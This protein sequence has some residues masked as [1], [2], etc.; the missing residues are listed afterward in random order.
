MLFLTKQF[1]INIRRFWKSSDLNF[2]SNV[3]I[4][5]LLI[6]HYLFER[7]IV[8]IINVWKKNSRSLSQIYMNL[9]HGAF[10]IP[11]NHDD[12]QFFQANICCIMFV[13][14]NGN[15]VNSFFG[16]RLLVRRKAV[17]LTRRCSDLIINNIY[18][19]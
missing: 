16:E 7:Y 18:L 9:L 14:H 8:L 19:T 6:L 3:N 5:I 17:I 2:I 13:V 15:K 12:L 1:R 4:T 11:L 10:A